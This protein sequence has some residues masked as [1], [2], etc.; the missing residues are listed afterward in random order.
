MRITAGEAVCGLMP[1]TSRWPQVPSDHARQGRDRL[2][3]LPRQKA[4]TVS[5]EL[6]DGKMIEIRR[7]VCSTTPAS[8]SQG[9]RLCPAARGAG[10]PMAPGG[11][12]AQNR[13]VCVARGPGTSGSTRS[14]PCFCKAVGMDVDKLEKCTDANPA[15]R[16]FPA[17][18]L[19]PPC[20]RS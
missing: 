11:A 2:D 16:G 14:L 7:A 15:A 4:P 9:D 5:I 10:V 3:Q 18:S 17:A 6:S 12:G 20:A 8:R 1:V 13:G 19:H